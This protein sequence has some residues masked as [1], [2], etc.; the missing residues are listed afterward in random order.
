MNMNDIIDEYEN[1]VDAEGYS[2]HQPREWSELEIAELRR[3]DF[4]TD[5]YGRD[6]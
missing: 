4:A 5:D 3:R 1:E 6:I 2:L